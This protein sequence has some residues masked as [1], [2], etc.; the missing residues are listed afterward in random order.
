MPPFGWESLVGLVYGSVVVQ[1][2][3]M[4]GTTRLITA[5]PAGRLWDAH[6]ALG[7]GR[8]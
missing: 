1:P 2:T 3:V 8:S 6:S 5:L 4:R 7:N